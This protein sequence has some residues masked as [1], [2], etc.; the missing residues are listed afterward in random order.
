MN[1]FHHRA[2]VEIINGKTVF[3]ICDEL[4]FQDLDSYVKKKVM[5][6]FESFDQELDFENIEVIYQGKAISLKLQ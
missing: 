5:S 1:D 2:K 4:E 3:T 6:W